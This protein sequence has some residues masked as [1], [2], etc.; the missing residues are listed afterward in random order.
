MTHREPIQP[1][2]TMINPVDQAVM[3]SVPS[4]RF[5]M[6]DELNQD[7]PI[8]YV[9]LTGYWIY[10]YDVTVK[11]YRIFCAATGRELPLELSGGWHEDH[12]V[13]N[14]TWDDA[15]AYATWAHAALPTEAQWEKRF[16]AALMGGCFP[17][18]TP[19]MAQDAPIRCR[20]E[21]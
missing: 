12:P 20:R 5:A 14:V 7:N 15:T 17:G 6:G 21:A 19:G 3:V 13:V 9:D 1:V 8:H 4:G 16:S 2:K 10:K 18:E 11:E